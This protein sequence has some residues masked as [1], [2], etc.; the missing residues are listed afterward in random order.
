MYKSIAQPTWPEL[1]AIL[2]AR[3]GFL[4]L[5]VLFS[6][7]L[8][9]SNAAFYALMGIAFTITI[10]Y[11]LW[12]ESKLR[13]SQ[14]APLQFLV[15][16][17]L[18]TGLVYFTGGLHS[19]LTLLYPLVIL[20]AGIVGTPRQA[21]QITVLAVMVYTLMAVLLSNHWIVE[22]RPLDFSA[23]INHPA[24]NIG[25]SILTFILFGGAGVY[26][27]KR[28]NHTAT[29]RRE[30]TG[31]AT[32]L[33]EGLPVPA[34]LLDRE[35]DIL[36]LNDEACALLNADRNRLEARSY[37][38]LLADEPMD[39]PEH[40]G[41]A[42]VLNRFGKSPLPVT[43]HSRDIQLLETALPG[44][45]GRANEMRSLTLLTFT[46]ISRALSTEQQLHKVER[47]TAATRIAGDMAH[48]I[49]TPLTAISASVQLLR[50][51]EAATSAADWLPNSPTRRD[52]SELYRH[53]ETAS[54]K[55]NAAVDDFITFATFSPQDLLSIIK[56]DSVD[57]NPSY[58]GHLNTLGRGYTNGQNSDCG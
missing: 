37:S 2:L 34:L 27:A 33:L 6:L 52:R 43:Y 17:V 16:L 29:H 28:C 51:Y 20:S 41:P 21:V 7:L 30:L 57:E 48:E 23:G 40:H 58:I 15:D 50:D 56:L 32:A 38:E 54:S 42:V 49:R 39:I 3:L 53:I 11:S 25:L 31:T 36:F 8:P 4:W 13:S 10:P 14:F 47:I 18:V 46:D 24:L 1:T 35:G 26:I 44:S 19:E 9:G 55:M 5:L 45:R 12:L 22:Y